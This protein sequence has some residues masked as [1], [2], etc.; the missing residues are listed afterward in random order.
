LLV[1]EEFVGWG[2]QRWVDIFFGAAE[3]FFDRLGRVSQGDDDLFV[4]ICGRL[5]IV[6][7][8]KDVRGRRQGGDNWIHYSD[9][10]DVEMRRG[11][12]YFR[13]L[14]RKRVNNGHKKM[15]ITTGKD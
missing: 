6:L 12:G 7:A 1:L 14:T 8:V 4:A 5:T 13:R 2:H 10:G 11:G 3:L 15:V 9:T